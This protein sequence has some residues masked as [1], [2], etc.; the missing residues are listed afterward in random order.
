MTDTVQRAEFAGMLARIVESLGQRLVERLDDQGALAA[1]RHAA[2]AG[3]RAE[4]DAGRDVLKVVGLGALEREPAA[5]LFRGHAALGDRH[6]A[7]AG[8]ILAGEARAVA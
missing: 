1:A 2:H 4:R 3:E 5:A 6:L 7:K 8:E